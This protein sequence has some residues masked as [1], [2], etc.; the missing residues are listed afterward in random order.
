MKGVEQIDWLYD[1][2]VM[3]LNRLGL[4]A[5]RR[6]L[7]GDLAGDILEIGVGTG[8]NL[9]YYGAGARVNGVEPNRD[10][11]RKAAPRADP[12]GYGLQVGDAQWLPFAEHSFDAVVST[13][14]F[15][16]IP[17][18]RAALDEIRRI[19]RPGGRLMQ[20]EHSRSGRPIPD[21]ILDLIAPAWQLIAGGCHPNRD[22]AA[23]LTGAGWH[24]HHHEQHAGGLLRLL[25]SMPPVS[26]DDLGS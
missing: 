8:L 15:C 14:V 10:L 4:G 20:L 17:D 11:L 7:V 16:T 22:T 24:L 18:P 1:A 26:S 2:A 3:P 25:I 19:L 13:L 21:T 23:L 5:H 6:R 12:R 9:A